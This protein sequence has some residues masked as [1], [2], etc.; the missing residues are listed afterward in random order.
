ME[1]I[2]IFFEFKLKAVQSR[3]LHRLLKLRTPQ[4]RV[5]SNAYDHSVCDF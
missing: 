4:P 1:R 5:W 2:N 3:C